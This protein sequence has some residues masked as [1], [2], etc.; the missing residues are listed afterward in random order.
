MDDVN[1]VHAHLNKTTDDNNNTAISE[2][3][4]NIAVKFLQNP[5]VSSSPRKY[6]QQFLKS[7]GLTNDE[8]K[9]AFEL[10]SLVIPIENHSETSAFAVSPNHTN[11]FYYLPTFLY[12]VKEFFN[13]TVLIGATF[14]CVYV[15]YKNFIKPYIFGDAKNNSAMVDSCDSTLTK[16]V[17]EMKDSIIK[18]EANVNK[19]MH[20]NLP[21]PSISHLVQELKQDLTSLKG[22]L[23]SR[24]QF[25]SAPP[26]IPPWQLETPSQS[27]EKAT[28]R[29]DDA[30][31][32]SSTNNSD[33]SLEMIREE[34]PK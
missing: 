30:A 12:K 14:Y 7:K 2:S 15:F 6:K 10:A 4:L 33:S 29:E 11:S 18:I 34:P 23:L 3:L 16:S 32:G 19:L 28:D 24:K 25:P 8:I 13:T 21:D 9:K 31:S 26:S 17:I 1:S 22:L 27:R 5:R 20:T